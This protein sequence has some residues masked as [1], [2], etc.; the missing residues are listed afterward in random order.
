[1]CGPRNGS[2]RHIGGP[3]AL[4]RCRGAARARGPRRACLAET[5]R[6]R[7]RN[8][9]RERLCADCCR[10]VEGAPIAT[11]SART[12]PCARPVASR[13]STW[14]SPRATMLRPIRPHR[15][16]ADARRSHARGHPLRHRHRRAH[17][18]RVALSDGVRPRFVLRAAEPRQHG[19]G[20]R[21]RHRLRAGRARAPSSPASPGMAACKCPAWRR[22]S[23]CASVYPSCSSCSTTL[24]TT[25]CTTACARSSAQ[26]TPTTRRRSTSRYGRARSG[27]RR[28][29]ITE[30]GELS[31]AL[32]FR[33]LASGGP[34]LLDVRIDPSVRIRGG[35]RVE[36]LQHMSMLSQSKQG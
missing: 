30:P 15:V 25:W 10:R 13:R 24:A 21:G 33:L 19:L 23:P 4:P 22:W 34:A 12:P 32:V 5:C 36:A 6:P 1:M 8:R 3:H 2:R 20:H 9:R 26:P 16:V 11:Q 18:V 29:K 31:P 27:C 28:A 7:C 35:G 17:A 14:P